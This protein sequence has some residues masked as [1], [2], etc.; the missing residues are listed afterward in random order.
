VRRQISF[1]RK[2]EV[3]G[4]TT[5][6][7]QM[8]L[9]RKEK[10]LGMISYED[11]RTQITFAGVKV[12]KEFNKSSKLSPAWY[13]FKSP[14]PAKDHKKGTDVLNTALGDLTEQ[15]QKWVRANILAMSK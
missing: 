15:D 10:Q 2:Q 12:E 4:F 11:Y 1:G 13:D 9:L 5:A 7:D 8:E 3:D 14:D 6:K